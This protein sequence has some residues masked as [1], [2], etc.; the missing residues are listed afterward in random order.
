M[1]YGKIYVTINFKKGYN[2]LK[3]INFLFQYLLL[4]LSIL[5]LILGKIFRKCVRDWGWGGF[6]FGG[7]LILF[8]LMIRE[9]QCL[10]DYTY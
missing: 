4:K 10:F 6:K 2:C 7:K 3:M 1:G 5:L 8:L 9:C